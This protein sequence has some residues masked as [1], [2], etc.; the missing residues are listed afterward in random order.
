MSQN[1]VYDK[2]SE[3]L[4]MAGWDKPVQEAY[5]IIG[6]LNEEG[7]EWEHPLSVD[8]VSPFDREN[9]IHHV[10]EIIV[11]FAG[12]SGMYG[13]DFPDSLKETIVEQI[14]RNAVNERMVH[15]VGAEPVS[16]SENPFD[17][18]YFREQQHG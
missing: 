1:Y 8:T 4:L 9:N 6:T 18:N 13:I 17:T 3:K 16:L 15:T 5:L 11:R 10:D 7:D 2:D 12:I 14:K